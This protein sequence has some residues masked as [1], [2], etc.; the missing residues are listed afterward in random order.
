MKTRTDEARL[1]KRTQQPQTASRIS[2]SQ[3]GINVPGLAM[4]RLKLKRSMLGASTTI[5]INELK[6]ILDVDPLAIGEL[7][8]LLNMLQQK[9]T[10]L[11]D[12]YK[13]IE[14][15]VPDVELNKEIATE[16]CYQHTIDRMIY[17]SERQL[18][19]MCPSTITRRPKVAPSSEIV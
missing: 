5:I 18:A 13:E 3:N 17:C 6:P 7:N 10:G 8:E 19:A 4:D 9:N 1:L 15:H 14:Q 12:L 11:T 2:S 16:Q